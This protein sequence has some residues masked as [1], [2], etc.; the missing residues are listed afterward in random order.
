MS[1]AQVEAVEPVTEGVE[2]FAAALRQASQRA[3]E[4][5]GGG[6]SLIFV[7][8]P[9]KPEEPA[10]LRAASGFTSPE[11]ARIGA[12]TVEATAREAIETAKVQRGKAEVSLGDRGDGGLWVTPIIFLAWL[13]SSDIS[14][15]S[16]AAG[17]SVGVLLWD[18]SF[19]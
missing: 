18:G 7:C 19:T 4:M 16:L 8:S 5:V 11:A 13:E 17:D 15:L 12:A 2:T 14:S 6:L 1:A 9:D 10:R 3:A